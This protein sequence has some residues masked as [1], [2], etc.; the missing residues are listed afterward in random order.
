[1]IRKFI[2]IFLFT[3][4]LL[5]GGN[6][7]YLRYQL[8]SDVENGVYAKVKAL[9]HKSPWYPNF[10][11]LP[12]SGKEYPWR[13]VK[14]GNYSPWLKIRKSSFSGK[15]PATIIFYF[16]SKNDVKNIKVLIEIS[17]DKNKIITSREMKS[18]GNIISFLLP[19]DLKKGEKLI[20]IPEKIDMDYN[21]SKTLFPD[22][23]PDLKNFI[24]STGVS[25]Y[26]RVFNSPEILM[27]Q[28]RTVRQYGINATG[29]QYENWE[30]AGFK[31]SRFVALCPYGKIWQPDFD[32]E[33]ERAV[34]SVY[35]RYKKI[36]QIQNKVYSIL[37]ADEP[38]MTKLKEHDENV[39]EA[40]RKY[41]KEKEYKPS[42][43]GLSEWNEIK[44]VF[45]KE[46]IKEI[47]RL[48]TEREV[49]AAEKLYYHSKKFQ[50]YST[51]M[52]FKTQT[53]ECSKY[54]P[55]SVKTY[56]NYTPHPLIGGGMLSSNS[57]DWILMGKLHGTTMP[58]SED[59][60]GSNGWVAMSLEFTGFI[61]D[62]LRG[63]AKYHNDPI[64]FYVVPSGDFPTIQKSFSVLG[65]GV[66]I[67]YFYNYG[68]MFAANDFFSES[69]ET[70]KGVGKFTRL[71]S[72]IDDDFKNA[73]LITNPVAILWSTSSE[74][75]K[76]DNVS[77]TENMMLWLA[78]D[79]NQV[80]PD[81]I[82]E[83]DIE[84]NNISNYRVIY[85]TGKN[86]TKKATDNLLKW[87]K[88]GGILWLEA[89]AGLFDEYNKENKK[90]CEISSFIQETLIKKGIKKFS[91][92][93]LQNPPVIDKV[94]G[95]GLPEISVIAYKQ[96]ISGKGKVLA[97]FSDGTPALI[98]K[99]YGKGKIYL[100]GFM[101][102]LSY[103][104]TTNKWKNKNFATSFNE[105]I[106]KY[107]GIPL[108]ASKYRKPVY[109]NTSGVET[110]VLKSEKRKYV[111]VV[112]Y[113]RDYEKGK[114]DNL[115]VK[116]PEIKNYRKIWTV[117]ESKVK[118]L[119]KDGLEISLPLDVADV[120][121][122]E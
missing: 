17:E 111:V 96:K 59:W 101:P 31:Y 119:N 91:W 115:T 88:N 94:K 47:A 26:K 65:R 83:E 1:M 121:V 100:C 77:H 82:I 117:T 79:R 108:K 44:P 105:E 12:R 112:N 3:P 69:K 25:G 113:C 10:G 73:K 64:G 122:I 11:Y 43:F 49:K 109:V 70:L 28:Y 118:I 30:K 57:P 22:K 7:W 56:I 62:L 107:F 16:Y 32:G 24:I 48:Y 2:Y 46:K 76:E 89:G 95:D 110:T 41:L 68:P 50:N 114:I 87:V 51:A 18:D 21:L 98:E 9:A 72:K 97:T 66:N 86:L 45:S 58:W 15:C 23:P 37:L 42:D 120:L 39:Q 61:V 78:L 8:L 19:P 54:F 53:E 34:K 36:P 27:K 14:K 104:A 29:W 93:T 75:W 81:F 92:H 71:I 4:F 102:G 106:F 52:A 99:N 5:F 20:S 38:R 6:N 74:I 85:A 90:L 80:M 116:I 13:W 103:G 35:E 67:I 60:L 33:V 40:F 55:P 63:S 84:E